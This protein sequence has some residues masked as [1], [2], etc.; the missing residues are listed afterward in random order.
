MTSLLAELAAVEK[1]WKETEY[2]V[3]QYTPNRYV[4]TY[5]DLFVASYYVHWHVLCAERPWKRRK[6][7]Q[8]ML[9]VLDSG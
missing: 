7:R 4:A 8:H 3:Y 9:W 5:N 6:L 1:E 2:A